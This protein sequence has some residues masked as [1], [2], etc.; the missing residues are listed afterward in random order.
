[1][2]ADTEYAYN[3]VYDAHERLRTGTTLNPARKGA[4]EGQDLE[5]ATQLGLVTV[6]GDLECTQSVMGEDI[7]RIADALETIVEQLVQKK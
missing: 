6:L 2:A 4:P 1:M 7:S 3:V 5:H